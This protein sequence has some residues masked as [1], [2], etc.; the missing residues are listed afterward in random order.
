MLSSGDCSYLD[1]LDVVLG[2]IN[3]DSNINI[4][5]VVILINFIL[6]NAVPEGNQLYSADL[7]SDGILN[8]QD[9]VI[10]IGI[11]LE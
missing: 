1:I 5:D 4:Q 8:V 6:G 7:N 2:D 9:V 11:I 10:L 3:A